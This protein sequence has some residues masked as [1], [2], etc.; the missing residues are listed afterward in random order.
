MNPL[1]S[2]LSSSPALARV[3]PFAIFLGMTAIQGLL[4]EAGRYW[5]YAAK[6]FLGAVILWQ[7]WPFVREMRWRVTM[8]GIGVGVV[9]FV[10]WVAL[11]PLVPNQQK[12]W[13]QLGISKPPATPELPWNPFLQFGDTSFLGWFFVVVRIAGTTLVVPPLEEAFYRSFLYRWIASPDFQSQSIG[14]FAVKPFL[15]TALIFGFAHNEWLAA[16][17]CAAA[18]QGLV[19]WQKNLGG[20]MTAHAVTN[21]LLGCYVIVRSQW[22]FW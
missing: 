12:L 3:L 5:I 18:Y 6:T 14:Q 11:D 19:C 13:L 16:V 17:L 10:L 20:A 7:V 22:H 2:K 8:A 9:I 15:L 21:L 1:V 4:G